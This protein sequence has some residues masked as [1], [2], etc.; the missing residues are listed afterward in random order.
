M[1]PGL[2]AAFAPLWRRE[3]QG[4]AREHYAANDKMSILRGRRKQEAPVREGK[5]GMFRSVASAFATRLQ[6]GDGRLVGAVSEAPQRRDERSCSWA[7]RVCSGPSAL[8]TSSRPRV[9]R[10]A[11]MCAQSPCQKNTPD[12]GRA[13]Q[14]ASDWRT[15]LCSRHRWA[16]Q[17]TRSDS[18]GR[19]QDYP[20]SGS[21][22][23]G[24]PT[25]T[26]YSRRG[27]TRRLSLG[28]WGIR[29]YRP[30]WTRTA[31]LWPLPSR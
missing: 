7:G 14:Q 1:P 18:P 27:Y 8:S 15:T 24:T 17:T 28:G 4:L 12:Q 30:H 23:C 25:P 29:R 22:T 5:P 9:V 10:V 11:W 3:R 19:Q 20:R 6:A 31:T 16:T 2:R 21:V 26:T 13:L